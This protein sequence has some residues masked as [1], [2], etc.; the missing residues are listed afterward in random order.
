MYP[1][2]CAEILVLGTGSKIEQINPLVLALLRRKR[3]AVEVQDTVTYFRF[4][5]LS[6]KDK[7]RDIFTIYIFL[8]LCFVFSQMHAQ[9][10]TSWLMKIV[11]LLLVW[12]LRLPAPPWRHRPTSRRSWIV[13]LDVFQPWTKIHRSQ[14][15]LWVWKPST[16]GSGT[17]RA[18]QNH[19]HHKALSSLDSLSLNHW[20]VL[21]V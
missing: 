10:S 20:F 15:M 8:L 21:S 5:H 2:I 1:V 11:W 14:R 3:I 16:S 19:W 9:P 13:L 7:R 18:S 6:L 17:G 12:S 4:I